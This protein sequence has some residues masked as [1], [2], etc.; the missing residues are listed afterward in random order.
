MENFDF[1]KQGF[2]QAEKREGIVQKEVRRGDVFWC[3][4]IEFDA[5]GNPFISSAVKPLSSDMGI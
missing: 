5:D 4:A 2:E 3:H 1:F